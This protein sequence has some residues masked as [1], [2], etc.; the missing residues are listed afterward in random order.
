ME[1][2]GTAHN[3]SVY[4]SPPVGGSGI[5]NKESKSRTPNKQFVIRRDVARIKLLCNFAAL[6]LVRVAV[7]SRPTQSRQHH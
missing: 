7:K 1:Y 3:R 5:R 6:A 2:G 4:A